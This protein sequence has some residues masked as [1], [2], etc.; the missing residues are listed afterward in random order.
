MGLCGRACPL[1]RDALA[2]AGDVR[3][4][5]ARARGRVRGAARPRPAS[6]HRVSERNRRIFSEPQ[7]AHPP[8]RF[9][10]LPLTD[11]AAK[12]RCH[13]PH[14]SGK[15]NDPSHRAPSS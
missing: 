8:P 11:D 3:I 6:S 1:R 2:R 14:P 5:W 13:G 12:A 7:N 10:G 4:T 9:F 15:P